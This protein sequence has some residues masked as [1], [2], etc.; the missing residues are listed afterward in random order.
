MKPGLV[1]LGD[2]RVEV[3]LL[4]VHE[5]LECGD[6]RGSDIGLLIVSLGID[7]GISLL[8]RGGILGT[9]IDDRLSGSL[10]RLVRLDG[11]GVG[12][13]VVRGLLISCVVRIALVCSGIAGDSFIG[14]DLIDRSLIGLIGR[15]VGGI[16]NGRVVGLLGLDRSFDDI[17]L[18]RL[19]ESRRRPLDRACR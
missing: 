3:D 15:S 16:L 17:G 9:V 6:D 1:D 11:C 19:R 12:G 10:F 4:A 18:A 14:S 2:L 7:D 13:I 5:L 8:S